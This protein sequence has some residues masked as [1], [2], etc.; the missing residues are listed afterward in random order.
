MPGRLT[1]YERDDMVLLG[2][3]GFQDSPTC[4]CKSWIDKRDIGAFSPPAFRCNLFAGAPW[5]IDPMPLELATT[6]APT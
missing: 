5:A 6:A 3:I 1:A 4:D 2:K